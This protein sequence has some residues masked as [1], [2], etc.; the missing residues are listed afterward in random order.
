LIGVLLLGGYFRTL[1]LFAWDEPSF[2]LHPDERFLIQVANDIRLPASL[3]EYLDSARNPLNPRNYPR[4]PF[5]VYGLLP[6]TL[7]RL[8]AVMLTPNDLQA[9]DPATGQ[10]GPAL[11]PAE[12]RVPKIALLQ[13]LLNPG[14]LN[15]TDYYQ[16]HKVGRVGSMLFDLGS[17]LMVFLIGRR[18]YGRRVGLLAALLLSTAVLPIQLSHFFTVDSTTAFFTLLTVYWAV[19]VAQ[20]GGVGSFVALGVSIGATMACRVTLATL[21]LLAILAVVRRVWWRDPEPV[22]AAVPADVLDAPA[23]RRPA[24][25]I[26]LGLLALA[27][28]LSL[29][30]FRMLQPDAFIGTSFFDL[31]PDPRFIEN[32]QTIAQQISGAQDTPP[33]EQWAGRA[34]FLFPL[35]NMVI[36]GLGLPLGLT[37]WIAWAIAGWQIVRRRV[38]THLIPWAWIAFYFLWQGGQFVMTMRY[39]ALLYG[40]LAIFAAW[41]LVRL[42]DWRRA[43]TAERRMRGIGRR[44]IPWTLGASGLA[45]VVVV[46]GTLCWAY[47]FT[48]IYTRPHSRI[49]ASRWIYDNIPP[50]SAITSEAWD[51]GLPL[52]V[53]G[54]RASQYTGI[55]MQPYAEDDPIKYTG[56]VDQDGTFKP[57]L[58]DQ[59]DQ[60]DYIILSSNRVYDSAT[61]LPMRYPALTRYYHYLFDGE[62]G[63]E[64]VADITSYPTLFGIPIPDQSA[65]EAFS[66]YDHPRVLIFKKTPAYTRAR[67]EWLIAGDVAWNEVYKLPTILGGRVPTALRLT[68]AQ[69]PEYRNAGTW[70]ELFRP[71]LLTDSVPWLIWLL[72]LEL[73]GLAMFA[74]LFRLLPG[75]PDR[76]FALAKTLA[77]LLVAYGAWLLGSFNLFAFTPTS[78]WLCAGVL[79]GLG[80][81]VGWR[82]RTELLAFVRRRR[83]ALLVAEGLFLVAFFGFL[84]VR[85]L[86]PDLWHPARGGE[87]PMDLAFLT[88]VLKSPSFPPYDPWFAGGYINYYYFGFVF[89]GALVHLTGIVPT[90]AYNLAVPTLFALTALGAWGVAYNLLAPRRLPDSAAAKTAPEPPARS[91]F[92]RRALITGVVAAVFVTLVGNLANAVFFLNGYAA[93][94]AHRP[95]WVFWDATR[96]VGMSLQDSTI[97]EFPFFTFLYGD[98]HAHMIALPLALA[99]LGLMV[100]L[101]RRTPD[102]RRPTP[103]ARRWARIMSALPAL[104]CLLPLALVVGALR[105]TNTWDYPAYLGLSAATLAL[106]A[107]KQRTRGWL[108]AFGRWLLAVLG[109]IVLSSLLFVPF[110]RSF[111]T[112]YAGFTLWRGTHTLAADFLKINGLWLFVLLSAALMWY[113]R[114]RGV[115]IWRLAVIGVAALLLAAAAVVL[116][117]N[118]LVLLIP[119][120]GGALGLCLDLLLGWGRRA[121]PG[122]LPR[123][124]E[125]GPLL[126]LEEGADPGPLQ[127][128]DHVPAPASQPARSGMTT[129]LPALWALSAIG[130]TLLTELI[131]AKGDI[132]RMNTVFKLGMQSWV[133]FALASALAL[134]WLW[135]AI[136]HRR[137]A[138]DH[139]L[140]RR[141]PLGTALGWAWRAAV[142]LV[143]LGALVYPISATPARIADRFDPKIGPTLDGTAYMRSGTWAENDQQFSFVGDAA[144]MAW[145]RDHINGTPIILEA[146][147]EAYRWGGR[148]STYTG[149]PTLIGWPWHETQQRSV[150]Q[151]GPVLS[152]RQELV[153]QLYSTTAQTETVQYLQLYGVEY[154]YVGALERA[155]YDPN[156]LAKFDALASAGKIEKVYSEGA[157]AIYHIPPAEH[158]PAVLTTSLPVHAPTLPARK[159]LMLERPVDQLAPV[160]EYAWNRLADSPIAAVLLWLLAAYVLLALGL[161]VAALVFGRWRDGGYAWARL[162]GLLLLGYAVWMPVSLRL[163]RYD[164]VGLLLG[165]LLVL[166]VDLAVLTLRGRRLMRH[167]PSGD[168]RTGAGWSFGVGLRDLGAS[169]KARRRQILIVE[170]LFLAA[171]AL[172]MVLR[173][174]NPDLW[175]PIWGGEKPFEFGFLNAILRSPVMPPYD[176][177]FSDGVINYYYYGLFLVSLPIK[178]TGVAP[179]VGFN[180]VLPLLFGFTIVGAFALVA[181]LTGRVRFGLLGAAFVALLGNLAT[182]FSVGS[183]Q[184]L[185]PVQAALAGGLSGFGARLG[186][187]FVGPS[188]IIPNTINEFPFWSF[189]F[190]DL[191]PHLIALP[192]TILVIALAFELLHK[193]HTTNDER[194]LSRPSDR[195][196]VIRV[197]SFALAALALGALAV[198]NSW[199]FPTYTLLIGGALLGRAWRAR[200]DMRG[201]LLLRVI[202]AVATTGV[203]AAG[204]LLLYLPFFQNFQ[205]FVQGLD[206]VHDGTAVSDYVL[207]YGLFLAVLT[208]LIFGAAWRLLRPRTHRSGTGRAVEDQA[209]AAPA[210]GIVADTPAKL[211]LTERLRT[212]LLIVPVLLLVFAATQQTLGLKLWL[213]ALIVVGLAILLPRRSFASTWFIIWMAV[214][215][216]A[217]SLGVE[218]IYIRDHLAGGEAYR[219]N[220]VFKFGMQVWVLLALAAAAAL[221]M[222][223]RALR[224]LGVVAQGIAGALLVV[225]LGVALLFP[226][227]GTAS[228]VAYRFPETTGPTLDGL[229]FMDRATFSAEYLNGAV[230]DLSGDAEAIRWLNKNIKGTPIVL[231]SSMEFYRTYGVRVAANT[232]LP[233]VVGALH[234]NEQRDGALVGQRDSEVQQLYQTS[235]PNE[236]LRLLSKYHVGYIYVGAIERAAY[237][238]AG[239]AKFDQMVGSYL[240]LAYSNATVKIYHVNEGV[241]NLAGLTALNKPP[242]SVQTPRPAPGQPALP[243]EPAQPR[244]PA[245][246]AQPAPNTNQPSLAELEQQVAANPTAATPAFGLGQMYRDQ[247]RLD[248]A[249]EVLGPAADANPQDIA[250]HQLYGDILRDA[251]RDDDAEAAYRAAAT[252]GP[253]AG[254]YN[255]LGNELLKM[256]RLDKAEEALK[257]AISVDT[258]LADPYYHLGEVYEQQGK[259]DLAAQNYE[260]YLAIAPADGALRAQ[261][262]EALQR[263]K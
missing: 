247:G 51:D 115:S 45:L 156:G 68:E 165:L 137:V 159:T 234:E 12:L 226:L 237:S 93:Q 123:S 183:S 58:F 110:T 133:L 90:T 7:T 149:L 15:M 179:A 117:A 216:W 223:W 202:G 164:R 224:R 79:L 166:L 104:P 213:G 171:F 101:V 211:R 8:G 35:T 180:L 47:A 23:A 169:L 153:K 122:E 127:P 29:I 214:V 121:R 50:G 98:L 44:R 146:H 167:A 132:G 10:L 193:E 39:Y 190:A 24:A 194:L 32:L 158:L 9:R 242:Q 257:Q 205:A 120:V 203:I 152:N 200:R 229:A 135:Q 78:V 5:Y 46:A 26:D 248:R 178:A 162:I 94:N 114:S 19:R 18:L 87:K 144:A 96:I 125:Q 210:I 119:L 163:W 81:L 74:L 105:A 55:Q 196:F 54:R 154:V 192:I 221:P 49:T 30:T 206:L 130:L 231:Q 80:A 38:L 142:A 106:L 131:V 253:T 99:A 75:L 103:D 197:P 184:G 37:A 36:W 161:P 126:A 261:A 95:E 48:R 33:G 218:L 57:G 195:S 246:P 220:T 147:T 185:A 116:K 86:N 191:H 67:A 219:M 258:S 128:P 209:K 53:D 168:R 129:L 69:W 92:E 56:F 11:N 186:D 41:A 233:T 88:A 63:F 71:S 263:V 31:R 201:G 252:A 112:D 259:R 198:T 251:G 139:A 20:G 212:G 256:G 189:L 113:R 250:L 100:A 109:L 84:I 228:R 222:L 145:M 3:D 25:L 151:V 230:I 17:I 91:R 43:A 76:G 208:P 70:S 204:A 64:Q 66:V 141:R 134:T 243:V 175:Q 82:S 176:P 148:V 138:E 52:D 239:V 207:I 236:A 170:G 215:A 107:W 244:Q 6:E 227:V 182:A 65:E 28:V 187:W 77:L 34:P 4:S 232:G 40:L 13:Q 245:Q 21:G 111:A 62:L 238:E 254:N 83:S 217:V 27:G 174:L 188:R 157:N 61:R 59:L 241:Y 249:I 73:L 235:D 255:K 42:W 14:G 262:T 177:F 136:A 108:A 124:N 260:Q 102:T 225:L 173:A 160:N 97:N 118:A 240:D 60:A 143:I 72:V 155:L 140:D 2:R 199:D 22:S 16:I 1:S 172:M 89:V 85:A 150:A 181:E